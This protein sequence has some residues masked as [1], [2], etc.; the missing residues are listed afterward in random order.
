[1]CV[2]IQTNLVVVVVVVVVAVVVAVV[3]IF[4]AEKYSSQSKVALNKQTSWSGVLRRMQWTAMA[5]IPYTVLW[6]M[7]GERWRNTSWSSKWTRHSEASATKNGAWMIPSQGRRKHI[8]PNGRARKSLSSNVP[9]KGGYLSFYGVYILCWGWEGNKVSW[10]SSFP[11]LLKISPRICKTIC[12][13][14]E[15]GLQNFWPKT[16]KKIRWYPCVFMDNILHQLLMLESTCKCQWACWPYINWFAGICPR[17]LGIWLSSAWVEVDGSHVFVDLLFVLCCKSE[18]R[19]SIGS[20]KHRQN[21]IFYEWMNLPSTTSSWR[22][23]ELPGVKSQKLGVV[24]HVLPTIDHEDGFPTVGNP[25]HH[26]LWNY[27]FSWVCELWTISSFFT[28]H[29]FSSHGES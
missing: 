2:H 17:S 18:V 5:A 21:C 25:K 11:I 6:R 22:S 4:S 14:R 9:A 7:R 26:P 3:G 13:T 29:S 23:N 10:S 12:R 16:M 8:P 20:A 24:L 1:M 27:C 28:K 15:F 19:V